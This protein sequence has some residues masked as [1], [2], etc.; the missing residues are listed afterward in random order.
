MR[1][2]QRANDHPTMETI[3]VTPALAELWL[4]SWNY[5]NRPLRSSRVRA[6]AA[7]MVAGRFTLNNDMITFAPDGRLL[8]GQHRL[9]AVVLSGVSVLMIVAYGL[10][11]KT[12]LN[13]DSQLKR[14]M[15]DFMGTRMMTAVANSMRLGANP[16]HKTTTVAGLYAFAMAHREP[17]EWVCG[18]FPSRIPAQVPA[19]LAR[20]WYSQDRVLLDHAARILKTNTVE[21]GDGPEANTLLRF[22]ALLSTDLKGGGALATTRRYLKCEAALQAYLDGRNIAKIYEAPG[23]LFAIPGEGA[24]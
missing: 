17:L 6:L 10:D 21:P 14:N 2:M 19:V 18:H 5:D 24:Q 4:R 11:P 7:D 22:R 13:M 3:L 8:N 1:A 9:S 20:A 23:E 15:S 16:P 12:Q